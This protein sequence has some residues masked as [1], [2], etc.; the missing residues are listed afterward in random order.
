[1][2]LLEPN[3]VIS[4]QSREAAGDESELSYFAEL[5]PVAPGF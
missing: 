4:A 1:M 3:D 2:S 5:I